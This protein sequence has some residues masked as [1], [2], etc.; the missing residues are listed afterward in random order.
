V[1]LY[2]VCEL[3]YCL[4][5]CA[6]SYLISCNL[7][8]LILKPGRYVNINNTTSHALAGATRR[9]QEKH[10]HSSPKSTQSSETSCNT[11]NKDHAT[12]R[13]GLMTS[14]PTPSHHRSI[15]TNNIR[16]IKQRTT[17]CRN[18]NEALR[19]TSTGSLKPQVPE[20]GTSRLH[21]GRMSRASDRFTRHPKL[22]R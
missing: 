7:D 19:F 13:T 18:P 22:L 10:Q 8:G 9:L 11:I 21:R 5:L 2:Y 17:H 20:I 3:L 4:E 15:C 1:C 14:P 16:Y 12:T 6:L